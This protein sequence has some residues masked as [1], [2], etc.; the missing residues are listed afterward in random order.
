[1]SKLNNQKI[2]KLIFYLLLT[3]GCFWQIFN[4]CE[5]YFSFNTNVFIETKIDVLAKQMPALSL[6]TVTEEHN[7]MNSTIALEIEANNYKN[8][9]INDIKRAWSYSVKNFFLKNVIERIGQANYCITLN[10]LLKGNTTIISIFIMIYFSVNKTFELIGHADQIEFFFKK[11]GSIFNSW[12]LYMHNP[13]DEPFCS[14]WERVEMLKNWEYTVTWQKTSIK[15][16][17]APYHTNC[18]DYQA[19]SNYLSRKDCIR[20]CKIKISIE[21]CRV[22]DWGI[23]LRSDEPAVIFG[24]NKTC[25]DSINLETICYRKCPH[26]D[27]NVE[28]YVPVVLKNNHSYSRLVVTP[29]SAPENVFH[30]VPRI[31]PVEFICYLAS[32]LSMWFGVSIYSS[33]HLISFLEKFMMSKNKKQSKSPSLNSNNVNY[34]NQIVLTSSNRF[35]SLRNSKISIF[36]E[37]GRNSLK[38]SK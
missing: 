30:H 12:L 6:C 24:K 26:Y 7:G 1:M 31:Q 16:L 8:I 38:I 15:L 18:K 9:M 34:S 28:H 4:V 33:Y 35:V 29:P 11:Y 27:C 21:M 2:F 20:R 14:S 19:T 36:R 5:L 23:E 22:L 37:R 10:S 25:L 13:Y 3:F 32:T 17:G